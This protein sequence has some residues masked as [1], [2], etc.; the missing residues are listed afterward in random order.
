M[1]TNLVDKIVVFTMPDC[2]NCEA[3][4]NTLTKAGYSFIEKSMKLLAEYH[5]GWRTDGSVSFMAELSF[6]NNNAPIVYIE[7][8]YGHTYVR[9][10]DGFYNSENAIDFIELLEDK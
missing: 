5:E 7:H 4:K 8:K 3:L 2:K 1:P 10:V 6:N 9:G